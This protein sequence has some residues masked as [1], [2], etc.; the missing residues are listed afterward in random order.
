MST[1][2]QRQPRAKASLPYGL[3]VYAP[4]RVLDIAW[5]D[6]GTVELI[7]YDPGEWEWAI[8]VAA[9]QGQT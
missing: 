7:R 2:K 6:A 5:D 3:D 1:K 4:K 9:T 8:K